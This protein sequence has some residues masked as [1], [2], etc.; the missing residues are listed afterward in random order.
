MSRGTRYRVACSELGL[1]R[2]QWT[3]EG[4]AAAANQWWAQKRAELDRAEVERHPHRVALEEL[5]E[6]ITVGEMVG[7]PKSE[8]KQLRA[9]L[10]QVKAL[11][12]DADTELDAYTRAWVLELRQYGVDLSGL[13]P[14]ILRAY[15]GREVLHSERKRI[16][17]RVAKD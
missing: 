11:P 6:Q 7:A 15:L 4:S 17:G 8:L 9:E 1:P 12:S 3:R 14:I 2:R 13:P 10:E 16:V 5:K